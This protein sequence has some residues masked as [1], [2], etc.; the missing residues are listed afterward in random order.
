MTP[1]I[2]QR[3]LR[4]RIYAR[5]P[6][7]IGH[8]VD[9]ALL[10]RARDAQRTQLGVGAKENPADQ[11]PPLSRAST[12]CDE[13]N[14]PPWRCHRLDRNPYGTRQRGVTH[15]RRRNRGLRPHATAEAEKRE[16]CCKKLAPPFEHP[17][18]LIAM[19]AAATSARQRSACA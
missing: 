10:V 8:E 5:Q 9:L 7:H 19:S 3:M 11:N 2:D 17:L 16:A 1:S 6:L 12:F 4:L 18:H 14:R 15:W 13:R